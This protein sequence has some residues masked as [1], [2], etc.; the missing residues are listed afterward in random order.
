MK[1]HPVRSASSEGAA[2]ILQAISKAVG[3]SVRAKKQELTNG[4]ILTHVLHGTYRAHKIELIANE[5]MILV[6]VEAR[7]GQF[8]L[9]TFNERQWKY[10]FGKPASVVLAH[11]VEYPMHTLDG[12]LSEAQAKLLQSGALSTL[13]EVIAPQELE[14][15][16]VSQRL[17]RVSLRHPTA[18]RVLSILNAVVDHMPHESS[19]S[20]S[21]DVDALPDSLRLLAPLLTKWTIGDDEERSRK[22]KRSAASTRQKLI[23]AVIPHLQAI[24][25]YLD[26]FGENPPED[27]CA[28]G[29]L[30]QAALEAQSLQTTAKDSV[31]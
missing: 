19:K 22:L 31:P 20:V 2:A 11:G 9:L 26:S 10:R 16:D 21:L 28:F 24:D 15:L 23:D 3:G 17:V 1:Q 25:A 6:D 13:L 18:E 5:E 12:S 14:Q 8:H 30:A 29:S 27:A 7:Y 4:S